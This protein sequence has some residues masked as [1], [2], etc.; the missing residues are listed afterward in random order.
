M[1]RGFKN[2]WAYDQSPQGDGI[3]TVPDFGAV[4]NYDSIETL[5]R[6]HE[7]SAVTARQI[8]TLRKYGWLK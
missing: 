3:V 8:A 6:R 2:R 4:K 7:N 1:R 5:Q